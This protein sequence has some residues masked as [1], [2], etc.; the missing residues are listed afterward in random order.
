MMKL[1]QVYPH[2]VISVPRAD[3]YDALAIVNYEIGR[4]L[5]QS[6]SVVTYPKWVKGQRKI[7]QHEGVTYRRVPERIDSA[8]NLLR[9][10]DNRLLRPDRPFRLSSLYYARYASKVARDI[11]ERGCDA[12]HIHSVPNFIPVVRKLNPKAR[13]ALHMHDHSLADFDARI[14]GPRLEQANL[15]VACSDFVINAIR[16]RFPQLAGRCHTLYN[17]VDERFL[18]IQADPARSQTVLFVGRLCPEKGVHLLLEAMKSMPAPGTLSLV[19]PLDVAPREFV[20]PLSADALFE[21]LRGFYRHPQ[22]FRDLL[23]REAGALGARA[24]LHGKV[25]NRDIGAH[26]A[27]A[28]VFVFPSLWHE[29]FGIPVIEAMAAGLPVVATRGG[30][31][32]EIV[33]E[34]ETGFLVERGDVRGL[35]AAI[36]ELLGN[37]SLRRRMGAA[38]RQR[39]RELFTW[40]RCVSR[41]VDLYAR[42]ETA[43]Q[44]VN[45][46]GSVHPPERSAAQGIKVHTAGSSIR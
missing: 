13:I 29:P 3:V 23:L 21:D 1:A 22:G 20:D 31:L 11:R 33:V 17:G 9:V 43:A 24:I 41:L 16:N 19:G 46:P 12:V 35:R 4:R 44:P 39:V 37:P 26:Y 27:Q 30:A 10:L 36:S 18:N 14:V 7:E 2:S 34:G 28:G 40:D 38:G 25:F 6:N 8:L 42:A 5:A 15:I 45:P 32:P